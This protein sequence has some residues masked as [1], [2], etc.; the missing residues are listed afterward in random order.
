MNHFVNPC[1][2]PEAKRE[3]QEN[4]RHFSRMQSH[5]R[6]SDAVNDRFFIFVATKPNPRLRFARRNPYP[7]LMRLHLSMWLY[8]FT[9]V[10]RR[11]ACR[12][13]FRIG[14]CCVPDEMEGGYDC[15][16][17]YPPDPFADNIPCVGVTVRGKP[18]KGSRPFAEDHGCLR[19]AMNKNVLRLPK[20]NA[21]A[22]SEKEQRNHDAA[23]GL[24][25]PQTAALRKDKG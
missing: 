14:E 7:T 9:P 24:F 5:N 25:K 18:I 21:A 8:F 2:L 19:K 12:A 4:V 15:N 11:T 22:S 6:Y 10:L 3:A 1:L 17:L 13:W 16:K 23:S 20:R